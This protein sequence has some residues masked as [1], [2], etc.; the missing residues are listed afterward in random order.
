MKILIS[1]GPTREKIDPVRFITNYSSGKMGYALAEAAEKAGYDVTLVT[2]P[3]SIEP[4]D[5][6]KVIKVESASEM[7]AAMK[8]EFGNSDIT[9][10]C[11]AVADYR[12]RNV[13][14][15][16][17]KK[18]DGPLTLEL[19]RTEDILA[20]LGK[21]KRGTQLLVG[22][23]AETED[24]IKN[25]RKKLNTKNLD[26]IIANDISRKDQ[27]FGSDMNEVTVISRTGETAKLPLQSKKE[28]AQKIITLLSEANG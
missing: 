26:F 25:A 11:A 23:A 2:G 7:A 9:I 8:S 5:G 21:L 12:P 3:V 4:P 17:M 24:L 16:K 15:Q 18:T 27:G 19:E 28:I 14:V 13:S 10:S 1:A 20:S 6:V 22:F